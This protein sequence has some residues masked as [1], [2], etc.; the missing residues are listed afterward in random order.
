MGFVGNNEPVLIE[1]PYNMSDENENDESEGNQFDPDLQNQQQ[2]QL[3][4]TSSSSF[5]VVSPQHMHQ[6]NETALANETNIQH[7]NTKT[8]E[9][10][11]SNLNQTQTAQTFHATNPYVFCDKN[12]TCKIL[13][14]LNKLR[15]DNLLCDVILKVDNEEF[16]CHKVFINIFTIKGAHYTYTDYFVIGDHSGCV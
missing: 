3:S 2:Q 10:L 7:N 5:S 13:E 1:Y 8:I 15:L 16:P 11:K 6:A 4:Q 14:G 9:I 12:N